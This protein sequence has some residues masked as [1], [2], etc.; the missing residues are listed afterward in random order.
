MNEIWVICHYMLTAHTPTMRTKAM[1][2]YM[3]VEERQWAS[4]LEGNGPSILP[5][6]VEATY[7]SN[8]PSILPLSSEATNIHSESARVGFK[9]WETS[10][11]GI[12]TW[13]ACKL[14]WAVYTQAGDGFWQL[15]KL[16]HQSPHRCNLRWWVD[17]LNIMHVPTKFGGLLLLQCN[18]KFFVL[19]LVQVKMIHV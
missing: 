5:L 11:N 17:I 10:V 15:W 1:H 4:Y 7:R 6:Y 13:R 16:P 8:G 18:G 12:W 9:D 3:W 14:L 19:E 2:T